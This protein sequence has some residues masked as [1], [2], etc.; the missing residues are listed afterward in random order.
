MLR[1]SLKYQTWERERE[2]DPFFLL[3]L[4]DAARIR[5]NKDIKIIWT[6]TLLDDLTFTTEAQLHDTIMHKIYDLV[7]TF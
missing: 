5:N 2:K 6:K 7:E 4:D 1:T 3:K